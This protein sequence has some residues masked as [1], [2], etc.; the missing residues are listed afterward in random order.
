MPII[1]SRYRHH[2]V[3]V[4]WAFYVVVGWY[5][6]VDVVVPPLFIPIYR[7]IRLSEVIYGKQAEPYGDSPLHWGVEVAAGLPGECVPGRYQHGEPTDQPTLTNPLHVTPIEVLPDEHSAHIIHVP[8]EDRH[9]VVEGEVDPTAPVDV[10]EN[11]YHIPDPL[12]Q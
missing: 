11:S 3:N 6:L 12:D 2:L 10:N 4:H 7:K 1:S 5:Y 8:T 9:V